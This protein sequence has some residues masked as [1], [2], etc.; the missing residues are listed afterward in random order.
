MIK[1]VY[2]RELVAKLNSF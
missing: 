1:R 2:E